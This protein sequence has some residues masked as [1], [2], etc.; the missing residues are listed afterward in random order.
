MNRSLKISSVAHA[1]WDH[2][3]EC[4]TWNQRL[5]EAWV[6]FCHWIFFCFNV[7]KPLMPILAFSYSLWK[8]QLRQSCYPINYTKLANLAFLYCLVVKCKINSAKSL[9]LMGIEPA[10]LGLWHILCLHFHALTT[11]LTWQVLMEG[12]LTQLVLVQLIFVLKMI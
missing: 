4:W 11:E 10:T 2:K 12:Y 9:P 6:T 1:S 5:W 7:V 8:T 3:G